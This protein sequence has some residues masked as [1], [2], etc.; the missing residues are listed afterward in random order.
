MTSLTPSPDS[1]PFTQSLQALTAI[2][3]R[4]RQQALPL[5]EALTLFEEGLGYVKTCQS[6]L[7]HSKGKLEVLSSTLSGNLGSTMSNSLL[8]QPEE[9]KHASTPT[10]QVQQVVEGSLLLSIQGVQGL[11]VE[12]LQHAIQQWRKAF[13]W[14]LQGKHLVYAHDEADGLTALVGL[15]NGFLTVSGNASQL[16]VRLQLPPTEAPEEEAFQQ[17]CIE[18]LLN[19]E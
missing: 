15:A 10:Q 19:D 1:L 18:A 14:R 3:E 2:L 11:S 16:S 9:G 5:E 6:T 4:F 17:A 12:R 7:Q 8:E 13:E